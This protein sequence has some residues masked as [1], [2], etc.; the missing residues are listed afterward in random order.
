MIRQGLHSS[1]AAQQSLVFHNPGFCTKSGPGGAPG[2]PTKG[3]GSWGVP[4]QLLWGGF[5]GQVPA[6]GRLAPGGCN[7]NGSFP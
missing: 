1:E 6:G 5:L 7:K 2:A 3:G 4:V